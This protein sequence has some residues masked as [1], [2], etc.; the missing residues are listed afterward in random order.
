MSSQRQMYERLGFQWAGTLL[1]FLSIVFVPI[2]IWWFY[3]GRAL[4]MKSPFARYVLTGTIDNELSA[5]D[6]TVNTSTR[7]KMRRISLFIHKYCHEVC[8]PLQRCYRASAILRSSYSF[9]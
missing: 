4:R 9:S 7:T 3:K 8:S 6:Y 1:A 2:P 5:N